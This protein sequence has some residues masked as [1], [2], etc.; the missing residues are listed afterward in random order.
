MHTKQIVA[1]VS[2]IAL[3][4]AQAPPV[5]TLSTTMSGVLPYLPVST[6]F[7]GVET[8][9]GAITY[10]G[11]VVDGFTGPGGNATIQSNLPP[12]TYMAVL[13]MTMFDNSTNST[14]GT[15]SIITGSITGKANSNGTGIMFYVNFAGFPSESSE[16]PFVYHIHNKPV[17][18]DGNCTETLGHLDPTDRGEYH[19]CENSQ[20]ETCQA[21]DLAGKHGN[22]TTKEFTASYLEL[23][24]STDPS[25]PYFFGDKSVVIHTSNTTRLTCANFTMIASSTTTTTSSSPSSGTATSTSTATPSSYTGAA[26]KV[27]GSSVI[28]LL[29]AAV[30]AMVL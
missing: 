19:P 26:S 16:G 17:P 14:N 7:T 30:G 1:A 20:P 6:G 3:V 4:N 9:E 27:A 2:R 28:G 10:D 23:Y 21:G 12:A 25:S 13:P 24:L 29:V 18:T 5:S 11:P 22:I 15:D 8:I